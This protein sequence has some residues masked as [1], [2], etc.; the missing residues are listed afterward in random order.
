MASVRLDV[1]T[2]ARVA[3]A[4]ALAGLDKS[5]YMSRAIMRDLASEG[6]VAFA[7]R[8]SEDHVNPASPRN[9]ESDG[10]SVEFPAA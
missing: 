2:H 8:K 7:K 5:A 6:V 9:R 3:A 1:G 4:A 10:P